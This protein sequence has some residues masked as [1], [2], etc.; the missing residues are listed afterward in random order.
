MARTAEGY[1]AHRGPAWLAGG[2]RPFFLATG[3]W[4]ALAMVLWLPL[5]EGMIALPSRL[6]PIDWHA[7]E[8]LWGYAGAAIAGFLLTAIP[9][10]TGRL[11][12]VGRPLLVLVVLWAIGRIAILVSTPLG[13]MATAILDLLFPV[14]LTFVAGREVVAGRNWRNLKVVGLVALL[15]VSNA[16]FH[17]ELA[18]RGTAP[19]AIR[20]AIAAILML[21]V[22]I[23]G[24]IVPS[25]TANWLR[26]RGPGRMPTPFAR[27][28]QAASIVVG[29]A[30][31]VWVVLPEHRLTAVAL[32]IAGVVDLV[33]LARWAGWRTTGEALLVV[34]HV[35]RVFVG[36]GC[37][38]LAASIAGA[39]LAP[40]AALHAWTVGA[41]GLTTLAV[42][43]RASLGHAGRPLH[44]TRPIASLYVACTIAALARVAA[45]FGWGE[46]ALLHVAALGW[47]VAFGGFFAI[48]LP[49]L[50]RPRD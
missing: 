15:A 2:F 12:V 49:I 7:H 9:N 22:V 4:A 18:L 35:A 13:A 41:I 30:L 23:G 20:I 33:R 42:M 10:W 14:G 37:L 46:F 36:L 6:A 31:A 32:A 21:V 38:V 45:G 5:W 29:V 3:L 34:L 8:M 11:P 24:R 27:F 16:I 19:W 1:R 50:A 17:V 25:F 40:T 43:T 28:D 48:Y 44:A 47:I 39:N 26:Q